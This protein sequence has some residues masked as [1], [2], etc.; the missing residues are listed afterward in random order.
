MNIETLIEIEANT[1]VVAIMMP[2]KF[3]NLPPLG[4]EMT[5][6]ILVHL[7]FIR[8]SNQFSSENGTFRSQNPMFAFQLSGMLSLEKGAEPPWLL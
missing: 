6:G 1:L 2:G 3:R 8:K 4:F 5:G 7:R